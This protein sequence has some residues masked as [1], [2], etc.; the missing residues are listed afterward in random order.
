MNKVS[1][2]PWRPAGARK[3]PWNRADWACESVTCEYMRE[4]VGERRTKTGQLPPQ[5]GAWGG[6]HQLAGSGGRC[7]G[8]APRCRFRNGV[9]NACSVPLRPELG[10]KVWRDT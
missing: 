4:R 8:L 2:L 10:A 9:L 7:Q 6:T 5:K 1:C 3:A